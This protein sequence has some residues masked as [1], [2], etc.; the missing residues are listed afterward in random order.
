MDQVSMVFQK[1]YLFAD[2]IENNI[3]KDMQD[4]TPS[5]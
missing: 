4:K 1:V 3:R 2:T 5:L